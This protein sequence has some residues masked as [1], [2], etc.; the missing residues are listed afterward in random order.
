[1]GKKKKTE[2]QLRREKEQ[3]KVEA[4]QQTLAKVK[5]KRSQNELT[6]SKRKDADFL[7]R[8]LEINLGSRFARRSVATYHGRS[9]N[10]RKQV[11]DL[12]NHLFV[13]FPPPLFLY[14]SLLSKE[15]HALV[16]DYDDWEPEAWKESK[17]TQ[18]VRWF[19][20]TAQGG[21]LAK[22]MKGVLTKK[23]VHWFLKAPAQNTIQRNLFWARCMAAGVSAPVSQFLTQQLGGASDQAALGERCDDLLRFYA[24]E[25]GRMGPN[26][27][28]EITDFVRA[29]VR[30]PEFSFKGRTLGSM[31]N[32]SNEWHD[33]TSTNRVTKFQHWPQ[34]FAPWTHEKK[35]CMVHAIELTTNRALADEGRKQNHCVFSYTQNCL[36]G[37]SKIVS[38]RWVGRSGSLLEPG[39][40][41]NRL[42]VEV[43]TSSREIYQIKGRHNRRPDSHEVKI[44]RLW[45]A[46][47]GLRI[48]DWCL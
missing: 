46:Y 8:Y 44:V 48:S 27:L 13:L 41:I 21:S 7:K 1:M 11:L 23:E 38:I 16:F 47:H 18:Y 36:R 20:V 30:R 4:Y 19:A 22:E 14:R 32:L 33:E 2:F 26:E 15:G 42:T 12:V 17:N 34:S 6:G 39:D 25:C 35:D 45:A 43:S 28:Q 10:L 40:I 37:W 24:S 9:Y 5:S 31:V 29:M 3:Q